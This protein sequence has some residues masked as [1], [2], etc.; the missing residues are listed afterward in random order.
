MPSTWATMTD[1]ATLDRVPTLVDARLVRAT[2]V[3]PGA[4]GGAARRRRPPTGVTSRRLFA[5]AVFRSA[6]A[7]VD[8]V[9]VAPGAS[10]PENGTESVGE[11]YYVLAGSGTLKVGT[12]TVPVQRWNAI[13]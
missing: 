6:W 5:P 2:S 7:Y 13:R 1:G 3:P 4:A 8:H 10:T 12:E 11:A 9:L